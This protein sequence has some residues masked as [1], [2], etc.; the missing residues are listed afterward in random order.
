MLELIHCALSRYNVFH[1][2]EYSS[3]SAYSSHSCFFASLPDLATP[4]RALKMLGACTEKLLLLRLLCSS[5]DRS[6]LPCL[7][8]S[9]TWHSTNSDFPRSK[10]CQTMPNRNLCCPSSTWMDP[11]ILPFVASVASGSDRIWWVTSLQ[12]SR[13]QITSYS[14]KDTRN[15]GNGCKSPTQPN[16]RSFNLA[17]HHPSVAMRCWQPCWRWALDTLYR[18]CIV[19]MLGAIYRICWG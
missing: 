14:G 1:L 8:P 6:G 17:L 5:C 11:L 4:R 12:S 13:H 10:F 18:N 2:L 19:G 15:R 7:L 9:S 3:Q 16:V